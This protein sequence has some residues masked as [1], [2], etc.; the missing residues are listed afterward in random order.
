LNVLLDTHALIWWLED[1]PRLSTAARKA[2]SN[3]RN[4][5]FVSAVS[6]WEV[7]IKT[8]I[9]KLTIP[10]DLSTA[11]H[12]NRFIELPINFTHTKAA[13]ALPQHH[14]DPFDRMLIAQA[15]CEK[16]KLITHDNRI[17]QYAIKLI[18]T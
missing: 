7:A 16:L 6:V 17:A 4:Q 10:G 8:A 18:E 9:G 13:G 14:N 2:I 1:N 15:Q 12:A 11:I 5:I 3:G